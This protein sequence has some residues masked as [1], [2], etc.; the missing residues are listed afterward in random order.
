M[1]NLLA[2]TFV[3]FSLSLAGCGGSDA[4]PP[5]TPEQVQQGHAQFQDAMEKQKRE[6]A[7]RRR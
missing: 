6:N 5:Q 2:F 4:P 3:G 7:G 1:R